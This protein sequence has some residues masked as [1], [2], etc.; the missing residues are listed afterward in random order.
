[1]DN[2][3][4]YRILQLDKNCSLDDIK[5]ARRKFAWDNHPDRGGDPAVMV[6]INEAARILLDAEKRRLWDEEKRIEQVDKD[7]D[8]REVMLNAVSAVLTANMNAPGLMDVI[9]S[10][11]IVIADRIT[12]VQRAIRHLQQDLA[13]L[14]RKA[15][16]V[17]FLKETGENV[18]GGLIQQKIEGKQTEILSTEKD[19]VDLS[20][21]RELL[22]DYTD[23]Q[24]R[25]PSEQ[26]TRLGLEGWY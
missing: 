2:F 19:L 6:Q 4:P 7:T 1:M 11:D 5:K 16:S 13:F 14:T 21:A 23:G 15:S 10:T 22:R 8:A 26:R 25:L 24:A 18:I 3:D 12:Q 17:R 20:R 9:E